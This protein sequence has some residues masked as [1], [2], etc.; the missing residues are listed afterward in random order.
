MSTSQNDY[1]WWSDAL[2]MAMPVMTK[3]YKVTHNTLYLDKLYAYLQYSDSIMFD[4]DENLYYRDAKYIYPKHKTASG[5][6]DFWARG[7]AWV[8]AGLA[9]VLK[10]MPEEYKHHS[11][12]V[13]KFQKMA[14]AVAAIQ[15]PE[16][17]WTRSMMDPDF[18]PG[19]ET[20]GTALFTYGFLWGINNGYLGKDTYMPV[21]EKAWSYLSKRALQKDGTVGYV[22]PIG[23]KP[24]PDK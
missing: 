16:G 15:Q 7:D 8:L 3:L 10:D 9:K 14:E 12:F 6:K 24:F 5:K 1:W 4:K 18:A 21:V 19:P 23:E 20:S 17:Y 13:E 2:Y 11:F 22:Q